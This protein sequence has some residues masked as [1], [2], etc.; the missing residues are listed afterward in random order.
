MTFSYCL[1]PHS[2]TWWL[3]VVLSECPAK[4]QEYGEEEDTSIS[5]GENFHSWLI[6]V[7]VWEGEDVTEVTLSTD[8]THFLGQS[9]TDVSVH[10]T[11]ST[12]GLFSRI[13][14][15]VKNDNHSSARCN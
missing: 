13:C 15:G 5:V 11:V 10:D 4:L 14:V 3:T 7:D 6:Y 9:E 8:R 12:L 2:T 1:M